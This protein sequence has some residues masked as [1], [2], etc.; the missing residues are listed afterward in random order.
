MIFGALPLNEASG[1][2]LAHSLQ[3]AEHRIAKGT[4]LAAQDLAD[5]AAAGHRQLTVAQL[6]P[7]DIHEDRAAEML[8]EALLPDP[9][10]LGLR[11]SGAGAGRVNLYALGP[12]L[13]RVDAERINALNA[14]DPMITLA[15]VP[16]YHR[17]DAGGM[18]AT[19]KII[20]YAVEDS[21]LAAAT[22]DVAG[23][24]RLIPPQLRRATLIETRTSTETPPD[25]GR[26]AMIGR[27]DRFGMSMA[28][29]QV[30]PHRE[31]ELAAALQT[32][33]TDSDLI[34]ILTGS[35]TSDP[36]DVAPTAVRA[37]GGEVTRF[38]MPVDPGNLLFLGHLAGRPV[39]GLP[40]CAR[41]PALN[42]ADWVLERLVC[43]IDVSSADIAA[44]GVGG[45][46]KE[47]P[48]RPRPRRSDV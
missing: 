40:G 22:R 2:Y 43:G 17:A 21:A 13:I 15:T 8:A 47:I 46:L 30:V 38:G 28:P 48:T 44:M 25:K 5:L 20:S 24:I 35:A 6:E 11:I 3:G 1:C 42:G 33:G 31:A 23:A 39:L 18:V 16:D 14:V 32:V 36:L 29:R 26:A 34:L 7:G 41:S 19:A 12:G 37:A 27:L 45:L 10:A 9:E 4:R